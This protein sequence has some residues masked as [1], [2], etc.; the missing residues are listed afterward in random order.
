MVQLSDGALVWRYDDEELGP[1]WR[2]LATLLGFLAQDSEGVN[3]VSP[4]HTPTHQPIPK[5]H[6]DWKLLWTLELIGRLG[7]SIC[8]FTRK[9]CGGW[10]FLKWKY[11]WVFFLI[12]V[13]VVCNPSLLD[14]LLICKSVGWDLIFVFCYRGLF[15]ASFHVENCVCDWTYVMGYRQQAGYRA[16]CSWNCPSRPSSTGAPWYCTFTKRHWTRHWRCLRVH[17]QRQRVSLAQAHTPALA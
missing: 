10:T 1:G 11:D 3:H 15:S 4:T 13:K 12:V 17:S 2:P 5:Q 8:C 6:L 9:D 16:H 14:P 7:L